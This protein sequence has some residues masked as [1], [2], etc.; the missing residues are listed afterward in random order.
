MLRP[1]ASFRGGTDFVVVSKSSNTID[2]ST[3]ASTVNSCGMG[4]SGHCFI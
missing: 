3:N 1:C 2:R 4:T